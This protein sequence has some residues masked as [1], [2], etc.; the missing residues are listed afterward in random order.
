ML[1][2][3][4]VVCYRFYTVMRNLRFFLVLYKQTVLLS[5][6]YLNL[7]LKLNVNLNEIELLEIKYLYKVIVSFINSKVMNYFACKLRQLVSARF[8]CQ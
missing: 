8:I 4:Y 1:P 3:P 5:S 2:Q 7:N 6:V